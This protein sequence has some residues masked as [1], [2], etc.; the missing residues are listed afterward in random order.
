MRR[1]DVFIPGDLGNV[2]HPGE[3]I[4]EA[5]V[6]RPLLDDQTVVVL[7]GVQ[8]LQIGEAAGEVVVQPALFPRVVPLAQQIGK[9]NAGRQRT[10]RAKQANP[11]L[12]G[13]RGGGGLQTGGGWKRGGRCDSRGGEKK[14]E[15]GGPGTVFLHVDSPA[16][17]D[18]GPSILFPNVRKKSLIT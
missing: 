10:T 1:S 14:K 2:D 18:S 7:G 16:D 5:G 13:W 8:Q 3:R 17:I 12:N 9:R 11:I 4:G 6:V 15:D